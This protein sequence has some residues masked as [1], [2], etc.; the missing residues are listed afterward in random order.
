MGYLAVIVL[1]QAQGCPYRKGIY[2]EFPCPAAALKFVCR[3]NITNP[4][5]FRNLSEITALQALV[6]IDLLSARLYA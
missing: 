4:I 1:D 3:V 5:L 2:V 6:H